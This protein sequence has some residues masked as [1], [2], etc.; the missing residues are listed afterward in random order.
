MAALSYDFHHSGRGPRLLVLH[1]G[2]CTWVEWRRTI[3][4]LEHDFEILAPTQ[5]GSAGG[6]PLDL[7]GRTML[8]SHADHVE[9]ML[10]ELGW[11]D[12]VTVVGSSFGGVLGIELA[13]RGRAA[14]VIALAPPWTS[15]HDALGFYLALF[16]P[17][18]SL[19]F[20]SRLW[21]TTT[22]IGAIN[23]LFFHTSTQAPQ[24][25]PEDVE[26]ILGSMSRF[27]FLELRRNWRTGPGIPAFDG[28]ARELT[29]LVWGTSD[30]YVPRWMRRRWEASLPEAEVIQLD[31]FPHQPH[32][33]DPQ[34]IADLVRSLV[35]SER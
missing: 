10:D 30:Y 33:R 13:N 23:G 28:A 12:S 18:I 20:P 11:H 26:E 25:D 7:T 5:P 24:I 22:R 31:G 8:E 35:R 4:L 19:R 6:P 16:S 27:P 15:G 3:E 21:P 14:Q 17:L 34:R 9:G 1:S 32:L 29:T 2:F